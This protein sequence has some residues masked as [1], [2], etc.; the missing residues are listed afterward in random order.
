VANIL[1]GETRKRFFSVSI[2]HPAATDKKATTLAPKPSCH[3]SMQFSMCSGAAQA[4]ESK[5]FSVQWV[6]N[7]KDFSNFFEVHLNKADLAQG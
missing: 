4:I 1:I 5:P 7:R 3:V 2:R 6:A